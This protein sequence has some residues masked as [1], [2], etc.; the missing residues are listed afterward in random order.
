MLGTCKMRNE[1]KQSLPKRNV[2]ERNKMK[3]NLSKQNYTMFISGDTAEFYQSHRHTCSVH[4]TANFILPI[5]HLCHQELLEVNTLLLCE[6]N[7][8]IILILHGSYTKS[9]EL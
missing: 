8:V 3:Q 4:Q 5:V 1:T 7:R 2:T 9:L 6:C